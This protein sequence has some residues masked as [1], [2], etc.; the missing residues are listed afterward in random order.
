MGLPA[1]FRERYLALPIRSTFVYGEACLPERTGGPTPDT[2]DPELLHRHGIGTRV[3]PG[4]GHLMM[5]DNPDGFA[6]ALA[7]LV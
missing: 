7:D 5:A 2:P 1:D 4:A 3:I 6:A